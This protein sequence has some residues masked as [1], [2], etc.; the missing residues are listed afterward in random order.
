[1]PYGPGS[2]GTAY[3]LPLSNV[4]AGGSNAAITTYQPGQGVRW[5][6]RGQ[7]QNTKGGFPGTQPGKPP[8]QLR[9]PRDAAMFSAPGTRTVPPTGR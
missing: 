2:Y 5:S 7:H 3:A 1:M 8:F 4:T 9:N 6:G